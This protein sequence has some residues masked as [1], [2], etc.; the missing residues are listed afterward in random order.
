MSAQSNTPAPRS[1]SVW[2]ALWEPFGEIEPFFR[3]L[4]RFTDPRQSRSGAGWHPTAEHEETEDA[5]LVR[6][7]LPGVPQEKVNVEVEGH[8]LCVSGELDEQ[9][10]SE[11]LLARRVGSFAHRTTLPAAADPDRVE[12]K[13]ADGVL[14]VRVPKATAGARRSVPITR[15]VTPPSTPDGP[16]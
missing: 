11:G 15:Q 2:D 12:A 5:F 16:R 8:E 3:N 1:S 7:E 13:L 14:T 6:I 9:S 10:R 4:A